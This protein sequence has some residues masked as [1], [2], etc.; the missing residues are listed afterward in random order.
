MQTYL[1]HNREPA[2][3]L[4]QLGWKRWLGLHM[5]MGSILLSTFVHPWVY[6][7]LLADWA[8]GRLFD[9]ASSPVQEWLWWVAALNLGLG[10]ASAMMLGALAAV[11]NGRPGLAKHSLLTPLYWLLISCA[12]YRAIYQ[13]A[14]SPYLW[15]KTVHG[16]SQ[17]A[18]SSQAA[19]QKR[20]RGPTEA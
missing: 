14:R 1:V 16:L 4:R 17:I 7:L 11:R 2:R 3:I 20:G 10:Y 9:E 8:S 6:V 5:L 19:P 18:H 13:L 15:E 12:G